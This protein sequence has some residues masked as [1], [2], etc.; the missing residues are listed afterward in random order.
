MFPLPAN[1]QAEPQADRA[2]CSILKAGEVGKLSSSRNECEVK[3]PT[4]SPT[5]SVTGT[6]KPDI[7]KKHALLTDSI[8]ITGQLSE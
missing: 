8:Y 6:R 5:Q 2:R 4:Q 7:L 1:D 3:V